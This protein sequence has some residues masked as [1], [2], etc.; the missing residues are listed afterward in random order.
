MEKIAVTLQY[1][2]EANDLELV[3]EFHQCLLLKF[4]MITEC[5]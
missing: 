4:R 2:I 1:Y 5:L 3:F